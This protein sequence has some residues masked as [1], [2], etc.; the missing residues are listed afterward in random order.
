MLALLWSPKFSRDAYADPFQLFADAVDIIR[1]E[2]RELRELGCTYVQIDA[3]ELATLV[4]PVTRQGA[5]EDQGISTERMLGEGI[6]MLNSVAGVGFGLHLCRGNNAGMWMASGGYETI[7][8]Q[9]FRRPRDMTPFC[10]STI[11]RE[12]EASNPWPT[13]PLTRGSRWV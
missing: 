8:K 9:V 1:D 3:P 12:P 5:Y 6:E 2:V 13:F 11:V 7:S 10:W 4:D